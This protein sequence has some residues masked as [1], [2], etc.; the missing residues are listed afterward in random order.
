MKLIVWLGNPGREYANTRH[1]I[2]YMMV[3]NLQ[4]R[5][6]FG[7][8]EDSKWKWV[9]AKGDINNVPVL[10]FKPTT[11]MNLSWDAVASLVNFY[12]LDPRSDILVISDDIDM[13]FAK[14][15]YRTKGSHGGQNGLKDIIAKLWSD[16]F[17]RI[18]VWIGRDERYSVSDW[19]LSRFTGEESEKVAGDIYTEVE[20]KVEEWLNIRTV[21]LS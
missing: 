4:S 16:E 6:G 10:L 5:L 2:G 14:I 13:D 3:D 9:I 21:T 7:S 19:V 18:K 1:N 15:R 17:S 20:K 12:K 8:W 11:Y